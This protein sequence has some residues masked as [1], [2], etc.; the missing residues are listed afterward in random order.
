[1][2]KTD[3]AD[4]DQLISTN[5]SINGYRVEI[6]G[7]TSN[8]G[9]MDYNQ[10]LSERRAAA[11]AQ[12]LREKADVP[13]WRILV[14]AGYGETHPAVSNDNSKDCGLNRR[15]EVKILVS[16]GLQQDSQVASAQP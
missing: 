16:K 9:G 4:L 3:K 10:G 5:S 12:Y 2:D 7:Y 13:T 11:V 6:T 14:P 8:T 1:L 15:V